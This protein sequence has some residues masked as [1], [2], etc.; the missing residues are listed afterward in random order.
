MAPH[1]WTPDVVIGIDF[2]MTCTGMS[3]VSA[4]YNVH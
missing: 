3:P 2:G 4:V 1:S